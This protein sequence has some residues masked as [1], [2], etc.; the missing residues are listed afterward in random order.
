MAR[1][2]GAA[3]PPSTLGSSAVLCGRC[4][5]RSDMPTGP[6]GLAYES[7][8]NPEPPLAAAHNAQRR[9]HGWPGQDNRSG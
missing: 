4:A 1:V 5:E 9:M 8:C 6:T 3:L 7:S 2:A